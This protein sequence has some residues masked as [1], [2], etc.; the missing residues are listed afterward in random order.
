L[1]DKAQLLNLSAPEMTVLVGGLRALNANTG[2]SST[3]FS[4]N[5]QKP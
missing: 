1:L 2:K 3:V 5:A 4:P